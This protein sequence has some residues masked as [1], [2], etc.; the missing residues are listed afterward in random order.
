MKDYSQLYD[1]AIS[2][3]PLSAISVITKHL[4]CSDPGPACGIDDNF[5]KCRGFDFGPSPGEF[6]PAGAL[7]DV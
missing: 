1:Y 4:T 3:P 6:S 7:P 2:L 5:D